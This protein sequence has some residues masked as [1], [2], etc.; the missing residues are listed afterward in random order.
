MR[1]LLERKIKFLAPLAAIHA[2]TLPPIPPRPPLSTQDTSS[3][4]PSGA[5]DGGR[6]GRTSFSLGTRTILPMPVPAWRMRS[7]S[8]TCDMGM[9]VVGAAPQLHRFLCQHLDEERFVL[10]H[11][12]EADAGHGDIAQVGPE[13]HFTIHRGVVFL[14][15][16]DESTEGRRRIP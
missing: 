11:G 8:T 13:I 10:H 6:T 15:N 12:N 3:E 1:P 9:I 7:A 4:K 5:S 2:A 14:A 16:L